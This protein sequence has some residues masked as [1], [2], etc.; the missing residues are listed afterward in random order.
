MPI[1]GGGD[2]SSIHL[3]AMP[4]V[5][6]QHQALRKTMCRS[7]GT[8]GP[9]SSRSSPSHWQTW[10]PSRPVSAALSAPGVGDFENH[11]WQ[12]KVEHYSEE[13]LLKL[14]LKRFVRCVNG[15]QEVV[16]VFAHMSLGCIGSNSN[17]PVKNIKWLNLCLL[18]KK[19][20][21]FIWCSFRYTRNIVV[22]G[23]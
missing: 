10:P 9:V 18:W 15:N 4:S 22:H 11:T 2:L 20:S 6:P 23:A 16:W 7:P 12:P 17:E 3:Q 14:P 8:P 1:Q 19:I 21:L 5:G 13:C